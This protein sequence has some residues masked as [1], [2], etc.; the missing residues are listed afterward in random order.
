MK[1]IFQIT[2]AHKR[3][4]SRIYHRIASSLAKSNL[5]T[6]LIVCD[7]LGNEIINKLCITDLGGSNLFVI[8]N[9]I[10]QI[11]IFLKL[12]K[13]KSILHF[14]DPILLPLAVFLRL[15][16]NIVI[17]DMHEN[18][19]L[20]IM[21]KKWKLPKI[22]KYIIAKI[23]RKFENFLL[24][25]VNGVIVAQP[26]MVDMY[27]NNNKNIISVGR[28][29][30]DGH[31]KRHDF[32]LKAFI[33]AQN[34]NPSEFNLFLVGSLDY[35]RQNDLNYFSSLEALK[36][37]NVY[38]FPNLEFKKLI[39]LFS[40]SK[41]YVHAT[42]VEKNEQKNPEQLEHFGIT[43]IEALLHNNYPIVYAKGGP[44]ETI[45][46]LNCGETFNDLKSLVKIFSRIFNDHEK[47]KYSLKNDLLKDFLD[48][49]NN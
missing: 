48:K 1:S 3:Y 18:L 5:N 2:V 22:M 46:L 30:E 16:G 24:N 47:E 29:T 28:F 26:I 11:K 25:K 27:K 21:T 32:I 15:F 43:I 10:K 13:S 44:A 12:R 45:N 31:T 33:K 20:Q 49:N 8:G 39:E 36:T 37:K 34:I 9:C 7:G 23:Y 17:F 41:F 19:D 4:D 6:T 35:S 14:H 42:G 38:L 40:I